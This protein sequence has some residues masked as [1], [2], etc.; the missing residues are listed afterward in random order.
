[1]SITIFGK[2]RLNKNFF[3]IIIAISLKTNI[4]L[5]VYKGR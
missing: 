4:L 5:F 2:Y 3:K 1:M